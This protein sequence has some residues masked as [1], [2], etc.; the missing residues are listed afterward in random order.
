VRGVDRNVCGVGGGVAEVYVG[1]I[2]VTA[3]GGS[4]FPLLGG[5]LAF[6]GFP[7]ADATAAAAAAVA[8]AGAAVAQGLV[9]NMNDPSSS[10][11]A[12]CSRKGVRVR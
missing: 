12:G 1:V 3:G 9:P 10:G 11:Q 7:T 5:V 2:V 8:G 4:C 6:A